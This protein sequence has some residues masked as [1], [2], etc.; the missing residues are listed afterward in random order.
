MR[1]TRCAAKA[2][3]FPIPAAIVGWKV[4]VK[5]NSISS[6]LMPE[7]GGLMADSKVW[8]LYRGLRLRRAALLVLMVISGLSFLRAQNISGTIAG[9]VRDQTG[10][11]IPNATVV[12]T[13]V[14][15][16][17]PFTTA[18]NNEGLYNFPTLPIGAYRLSVEAKGFRKYVGT[19]ITLHVNES[20]TV[21]VS[22]VVGQ[23]SQAV[24][25]TA[26]AAPVNT[27][28]AEVGS[29]VNGSQVRELPLNGRNFVAL[30]TLIPGIAPGPSGELDTFDVGLLGATHMSVNG[31]AAN[32]NLWLVNGVINADI[33]SNG[34]LLVFPSIDAISEF[35]ILRNN[36]SAEF[37]FA[38][39]GIVNVVTRSGGQK[40]H[41]TAFEFAR[42]DKLDAADFFLNAASLQ[43]NKLRF[44]NF[45]WTASGPVYIPGHYNTDKT[46]DFFFFSQEW[47]RE[48]R[49]GTIRMSVPSARQRLGILD[50]T[51]SNGSPQPCIP[52]PAD[53]EEFTVTEPNVAPY[54]EAG[55][56]APCI[57]APGQSPAAGTTPIT[58]D[59]N[60]V[61][62]MNRYPLPNTAGG[63]NYTGSRP[64]FTKWREDLSR[65]DH[66]FSDKT[67]LMVNWVHDTW[68]QDNTALWGDAPNPT[69]A[70][71]WTQPSNVITAR[72]TR[73]WSERMVS[74]FQFAYSDNDIGWVS[75]KSC[76]P[77][78]CS[79]QG[80]TYTEI[81]PL[82]NGQF[83][84]LFL[85][86]G[87][88]YLQHL[89]PYTNRTDILQFTGDLN[90]V[91][92]KHSLKMG[93]TD[94]F[95][96]K[97]APVIADNPTAGT[98]VALNLEQ[99]LLG[100]IASY[101]E[102]ENA[103]TVPTRWHDAAVYAND[104][105]KVLPNLSVNLGLRWQLIGQPYSASNQISNFFPN[106]YNPA[107]APT[108]NSAGEAL[109]GT[110]NPTNGLITP[111]SSSAPG[112][113]LVDNHYRDFEPR[114]GF[115]YDPF[116]T[117]KFVLRGGFGIYHTQDSVDHLVNIGLN[118]PWDETAVLT[119]LT[120]S[121]IGPVTA[122]TPEPIPA[123]T[124]LDLNRQNGV[125]YQYSF[126]LQYALAANT[127]L[128][129]DYVGSH[130]VHL[131]RNR[132]INQVPP[133]DQL[134]VANGAPDNLF[135]PYLGYNE[136]MLN[137]RAGYSRYNS[138]QA[139]LN[140]RLSHGLQLQLAY[141]FSHSFSDAP[142][143]QNGAGAA[144]VQDAYHPETNRGFSPV[145]L[146]QDLVI[147]YIWQ[148][149]FFDHRTG[150]AGAALKGW[151]VSGI[152]TFASGEPTSACLPFDNAGIGSE[153]G[154]CELPNAIANP[155]LSRS[156]RTVDRY[157][158]PAAF[159]L[160]AAG[161]FGNSA[162]DN[163][164]Q[165]GVNNW[166]FS[167]Y[168]KFET[169]WLGGNSWGEK[170]ELQFRAEFFNVA[171]HTQFSYLDTTFGV[172]GFGSAVATRGP[173]E[174]QFSLKFLW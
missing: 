11:V 5:A 140:R 99:L 86:D 42:N 108:L 136:I 97:P 141:T 44:N 57:T 75:A 4:E 9:T 158:N 2:L 93:A 166:D 120:F 125:S 107:Q 52:Q 85:D 149:P 119:N 1:H 109:Y 81:F 131:G 68:A 19:G 157:F 152:T 133:E 100:N 49:G 171:N 129:L 123:L 150:L 67:N 118:P 122:G 155:N 31:N 25:V 159:T 146:P 174:I 80:F 77:S 165:P 59:P 40:F 137:E 91:F 101:S 21:D 142:N 169:P 170:G 29:L 7:E 47:R 173:R 88:T 28:N 27:Q 61:A 164:R 64:A 105:Y 126:G 69:I 72:L 20:L 71:D 8:I 84:S 66:Y 14:E 33:G 26:Q 41:G 128:E 53:P 46:K 162:P 138:L 151:Q 37:G 43:K 143:D 132:D 22:L 70:S 48:I 39:G 130:Q 45:G 96:R 30:T 114:V 82:T 112:R 51:C 3:L 145:D 117:N 76:P 167:V 144:P 135:R 92:G 83:P 74:T 58:L 87:F 160:P 16:S 110:G 168:K 95:L 63:V 89:P 121:Q 12:A 127:T 153:F 103:N 161:T 102:T 124:G 35:T 23:V 106:L 32:A 60:A 6:K 38:S 13:R 73:T 17:S 154:G 54:C 10:A 139:S 56:T 104:N 163:I 98:V 50:P 62:F 111:A 55:V 147:N 156:S 78:L 34:T 115:A 79:R 116:K 94:A 18:T 90:Y 148:I 134:A 15:T 172:S 65:W 113:G 24:E 36:Y